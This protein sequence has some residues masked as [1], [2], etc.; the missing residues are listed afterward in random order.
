MCWRASCERSFV[1]IVLKLL[2]SRSQEAEL[3]EI[4]KICDA[5]L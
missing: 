3:V 1:K 4:D 5:S 2:K